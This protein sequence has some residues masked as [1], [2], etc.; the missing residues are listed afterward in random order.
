MVSNYKTVLIS[1]KYCVP[2]QNTDF[3]DMND[4]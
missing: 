2:L 4:G 1:Y 3:I